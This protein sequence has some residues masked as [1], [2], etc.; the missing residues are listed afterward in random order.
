M[1]VYVHTACDPSSQ[2]LHHHPACVKLDSLKSAREQNS[3]RHFWE[4]YFRGGVQNQSSSLHFPAI[5]G[6][7]SVLYIAHAAMYCTPSISQCQ[8]HYPLFPPYIILY[9]PCAACFDLR[10]YSDAV[11]RPISYVLLIFHK[12]LYITQRFHQY[13]RLDFNRMHV[14]RDVISGTSDW[15]PSTQDLRSGRQ[16]DRTN[17][18]N[19]EAY[20]IRKNHD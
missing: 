10:N 20:I 7:M 14:A 6:W 13:A 2:S 17:I 8:W 5:S 15:R 3:D 19:A 4:P 1:H 16:L 12:L 11:F 18:C 9:R